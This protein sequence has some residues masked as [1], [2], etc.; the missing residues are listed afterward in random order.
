MNVETE[1]SPDF[2]SCKSDVRD[3]CTVARQVDA[4]NILIA[5][6]VVG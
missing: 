1:E 2:P 4:T 5:A 3:V 6:K